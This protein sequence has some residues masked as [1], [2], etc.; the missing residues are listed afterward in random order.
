MTICFVLKRQSSDHHYKNFKIWYSAVQI[1]LV[2]WDPID[3]QR[4]Y[5]T[6]FI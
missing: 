1:E 6:K 4:L 2:V 3:F 5:N